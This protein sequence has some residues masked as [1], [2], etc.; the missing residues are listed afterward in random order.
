M[1]AHMLPPG[2]PGTELAPARVL[3]VD[4]V[5]AALALELECQCAAKF[6][7]N[8]QGHLGVVT[9]PGGPFKLLVRVRA[10]GPTA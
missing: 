2:H 9:S 7:A 5:S 6:S 8:L 10:N 1:V 4:A 3:P